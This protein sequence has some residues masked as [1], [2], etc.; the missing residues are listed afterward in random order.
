MTAKNI[1]KDALEL[2]TFDEAFAALDSLSQEGQR[3]EFK[4]PS[5]GYDYAWPACAFAN[6]AGGIVAVGFEDP[7]AG[8]LRF[9]ADAPEIGDRAETALIS[10]IVARIQPPPPIEIKGFQ[11]DDASRRFIV[12][13]VSQSNYG[14]HEYIVS[15]Q[16]YSL[17]VRRGKKIG[18]LT[19]AEIQLIK[20]RNVGAERS[21]RVR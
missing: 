7:K 16:G 1:Y 21:T 20:D 3:L 4:R 2:F 15:D 19:L 9:S 5:G 8:P 14:P 13:R 6:A 11:S 18:S 17:P 10:A 12:I